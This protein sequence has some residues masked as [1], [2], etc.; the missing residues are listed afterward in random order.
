MSHESRERF[1]QFSGT[2]II[3]VNDDHRKLIPKRQLHDLSSNLFPNYVTNNV[4]IKSIIVSARG[5]AFWR[6]KLISG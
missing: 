5:F 2:I 3:T 6:F 4:T 1:R